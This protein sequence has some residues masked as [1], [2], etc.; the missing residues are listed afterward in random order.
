[1]SD[2]DLSVVWSVGNNFPP[3]QAAVKKEK[4][5]AF[6]AE[7]G[8][9]SAEWATSAPAIATA[10][11]LAFTGLSAALGMVSATNAAREAARSFA[12]SA[13]QV[14]ATQLA[15]EISG[16]GAKVAINPD[17]GLVTVTVQQS[18]PGVLGKLGVKL[19]G[20]HRAVLEPGVAPEVISR[21][22]P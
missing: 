13:D 15:H 6:P 17:G 4:Q 21:S 7:S 9:V 1:M 2:I 14:V 19:T 20:R 16:S 5:R 8:M 12:I 11:I 10:L 22:I 18:A 3:S